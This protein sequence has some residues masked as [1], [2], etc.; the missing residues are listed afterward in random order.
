MRGGP[1]ALR[2]D[3]KD[4]DGDGGQREAGYEAD[5]DLLDDNGNRV[6]Q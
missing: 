5:A 3:P 4:G 1:L 6:S 2:R